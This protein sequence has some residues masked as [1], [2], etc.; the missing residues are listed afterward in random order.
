MLF[1]DE[2]RPNPRPQML[3]QKSCH[4]P[5]T[6]VFPCLQ[7]TSRQDTD[8][9][10]VR[11]HQVGHDFGEFYFIFEGRDFALGPWKQG[12]Q[13]VDVVGV[14]FGDMWVGN[15]NEGQITKR[16]DAVGEAGGE[17]GEGEIGGG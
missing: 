9:V 12:G 4:I 8:C 10:A 7:E 2:A 3:V 1:C 15:D 16:L 17:D 11:L 6:N 13:R 14:N 5:G